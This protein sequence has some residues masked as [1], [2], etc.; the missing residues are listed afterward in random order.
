MYIILYLIDLSVWRQPV[1]EPQYSMEELKD[2]NWRMVIC[3]HI[4]TIQPS[5]PKGHAIYARDYEFTNRTFSCVNSWGDVESKPPI[6]LN[7]VYALFYVSIA[8]CDGK[9][10]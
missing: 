4:P 10:N 9:M 2:K 7:Q 5:P 3:Y 8:D 1:T 6:K